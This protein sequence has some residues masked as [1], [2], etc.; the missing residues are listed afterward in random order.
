MSTKQLSTTICIIGA[1]PAGATTSIFLSKM[2]IEHVIVDAAIFPRHKVCGDGLDLKTVRM[3]NHIDP[4]IIQQELVNHPHFTASWGVRSITPK[5]KQRDFV[6]EPTIKDDVSCPFFVSKRLHFDAFLVNK[7]DTRYADFRQNTKITSIEKDGKLWKLQAVENGEALE[8][9]AK[10]LIGA[11]GD[12]SILLKYLGERKINR[13]HYAGSVRQYWQGIEGL[14]ERNLLELYYP[15]DLPMS[16]FWI[17]PLPNGEANVGYGMVS[18]L[19]SKYNVNIRNKFK[20]MIASDAAIAHRFKNA[21]PVGEA[22]GWGLP[23]A[24]VKRKLF[25]DGW[26]LTGDA[27]SMISPA[28]G[29]GIGSGMLTSYIA[30]HFIERA[31]QVNNFEAS[32]F[33]NYDREV[34]KSMLGEIKEYNFYMNNNP[35]MKNWVYNKLLADNFAVQAYYKYKMKGWM[36]QAYNDTIKVNL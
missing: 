30:A 29:E 6:Y 23:L 27:A 22:E 15:K 26:L 25:G 21:T 28:N 7:I 31:V 11:D 13:R 5:G 35:G 2:G 10:L 36:N 34:Y 14:H 24:S 8:I 4:N 9:D 12:H 18:E 16:Y 33:A 19:A 20:D 1:G 17:F 3:L 32:M